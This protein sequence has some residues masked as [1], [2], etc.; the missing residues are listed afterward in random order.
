VVP[1][2]L[3]PGRPGPAGDSQPVTP[4]APGATSRRQGDRIVAVSQGRQYVA[5]DVTAFPTA[6]VEM[7]PIV[8]PKGKSDMNQFAG[9]AAG[10]AVELSFRI[11]RHR[12]DLVN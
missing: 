11:F 2:S 10:F 1:F 4:D 6:G 9:G 3:V 5:I 12:F 7:L 8:K